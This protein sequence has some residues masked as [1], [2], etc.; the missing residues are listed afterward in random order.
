MVK[1]CVKMG[2]VG[3][4]PS[5]SHIQV[6]AYALRQDLAYASPFP[7]MQSL[8]N[9]PAYSRIELRMHEYK[10]CKQPCMQE[11][12]Q[13]HFFDIFKEASSKIHSMLIPYFVHPQFT[14]QT[15]K[16]PK[17]LFSLHGA[18]RTSRMMW[19]N[20]FEQRNTQNAFFS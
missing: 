15:A 4:L 1:K 7:R 2:K 8:K 12:K 3:L 14:C 18:M 17:I 20:L 16:N 9:I 13:R 11:H 6:K 5:V 10:L 19:H